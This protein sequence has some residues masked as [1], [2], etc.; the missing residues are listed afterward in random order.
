MRCRIEGSLLSIGKMAAMNHTTIPTL[1]LYDKL[2]LLK[3]SHV[4][5][6]T[7]YRYYD[8]Q[9]NAR[10][11]LIEYMK[12]LGMSLKEIASVLD[13]HDSALVE[14]ILAQKNEQIHRQIRGLKLRHDAIERAISSLERY[15]KSP[16]TGTISLEYIDRRLTYG[17]PCPEDFYAHDISSYERDLL[18]L[19]HDLMDKG[20]PQIHTYSVGTS[21]KRDDYASGIFRADRVFIFADKA[22]EDYHLSMDIIDSG[23]YACIYLDSYDKEIE[24]AS[25]LLSHCKSEGLSIC[26]DYICEVLTEFNV[27]DDEKRGMFLRLQVPVDFS[28]KRI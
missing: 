22:L 18:Y 19:R 26:G 27:F 5:I 7:G 14:T 2:G 17:I 1:R 4:D 16:A 9:Q 25:M 23:M 11:D 12:E 13:C 3:P 10:F 24:G 6:K 21:I 8:I 20:I 15:R 28:R